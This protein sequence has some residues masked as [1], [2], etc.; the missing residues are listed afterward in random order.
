IGGRIKLGLHIQ[1]KRR[2]SAIQPIHDG[3]GLRMPDPRRISCMCGRSRRHKSEPTTSRRSAF[4]PIHDWF[5]KNRKSNRLFAGSTTVAYVVAQQ[6]PTRPEFA[7]VAVVHDAT[8]SSAIR[9]PITVQ[10]DT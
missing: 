2:E 9:Q 4:S 10:H 8:R 6:S 7:C 5:W 1:P 3:R